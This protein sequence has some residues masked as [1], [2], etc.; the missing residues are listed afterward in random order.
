MVTAEA[1]RAEARDQ[2]RG[3]KNGARRK[4][5]AAVVELAKAYQVGSITRSS[6]SSSSAGVQ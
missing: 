2:T 5:S 3:E 1:D 4:D 6:S